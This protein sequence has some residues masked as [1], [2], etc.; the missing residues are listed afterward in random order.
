MFNIPNIIKTIPKVDKKVENVY[1]SNCEV[2]ATRFQ[3]GV[4][5]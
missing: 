1:Y 2:G 3:R 4:S 5:L